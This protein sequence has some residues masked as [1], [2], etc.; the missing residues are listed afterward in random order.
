MQVAIQ[1]EDL[2]HAIKYII[3]IEWNVRHQKMSGEV[4]NLV[5]TKDNT[6]KLS[7]TSK[8]IE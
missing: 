3:T 6:S 7:Y 4:I 1:F 2:M 8:M 5:K